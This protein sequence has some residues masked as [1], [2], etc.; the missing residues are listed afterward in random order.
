MKA[1]GLDTSVVLRLVT[2]T[3][4]DQAARAL[5]LLERAQQDG[6]R[7]QVSDLVV[8][9]TFYALLYHYEVPQA[10]ALSTLR[11]FLSSPFIAPMGHAR[12]VLEEY[13]G[14]GAGLMDRLIRS[15]YLDH[16]QE[17]ATFDREMARLP[18]VRIPR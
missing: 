13:A 14:K 9:E 2:G 1:V 18:H 3:P 5:A 15:E 8:G 7:V 4:E 10:E 12:S 6:V 17:V 11:D 16:A